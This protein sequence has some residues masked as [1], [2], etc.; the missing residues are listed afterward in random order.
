MCKPLCPM[1]LINPTQGAQGRTLYASRNA[2]S[3]ASTPLCRSGW[4][5]AC[6]LE[7]QPDPR[8][9]RG[10]GPGCAAGGL[11]AAALRAYYGLPQLP[12]CGHPGEVTEAGLAQGLT[13]HGRPAG[14][15][16][17]SAPWRWCS[18]AMP[19]GLVEP[20]ASRRRPLMPRGIAMQGTGWTPGTRAWGG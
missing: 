14:D 20:R 5:C 6:A 16:A 3:I 18:A 1:P 2:T 11:G 17:A 19:R 10:R 13:A 9:L 8:R 15:C 4:G 12:R 7:G